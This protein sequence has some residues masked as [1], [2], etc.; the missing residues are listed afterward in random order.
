MKNR[1][2]LSAIALACGFALL[3]NQVHAEA[4]NRGKVREFD[5][6]A[7]RIAI[8]EGTYF[9]SRDATF[10]NVAGGWSGPAALRKGTSVAFNADPDGTITEIVILPESAERLRETGYAPAAD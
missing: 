10:E 4:E 5:Q 8:D 6:G 9:L 2:I 1:N 7:G 3:T